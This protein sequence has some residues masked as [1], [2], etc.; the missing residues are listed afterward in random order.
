MT[1]TAMPLKELPNWQTTAATILWL[2][3]LKGATTTTTTQ[4]LISVT[5]QL[6][7]VTL[8]TSLN[9][10]YSPYI[11]VYESHSSTIQINAFASY[12][13]NYAIYYLLLKCFLSPKLVQ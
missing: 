7:Q 11:K 2:L 8:C 3:C 10:I 4:V 9:T 13:L 1:H 6:N 12:Q 5:L